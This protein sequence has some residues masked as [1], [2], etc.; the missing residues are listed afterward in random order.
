MSFHTIVTSRASDYAPPDTGV[1]N[2]QPVAVEYLPSIEGATEI[3]INVTFLRG[4]CRGGA[5]LR[6]RVL[7]SS[8]QRAERRPAPTGCIPK[9]SP[10]RGRRSGAHCPAPPCRKGSRKTALPGFPAG[11]FGFGLIQK[12]RSVLCRRRRSGGRGRAR[13]GSRSAS[14]SAGTSCPSPRSRRRSGPGS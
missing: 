6:P 13:R 7:I 3:L 1:P 4:P 10:M 5:L 2:L 11:R 12:P 9:A 14:S 8:E